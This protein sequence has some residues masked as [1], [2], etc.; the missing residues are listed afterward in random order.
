MIEYP[1]WTPF[2]TLIGFAFIFSTVQPN[3]FRS[4]MV[5]I[6][7]AFILLPTIVLVQRIA[8]RQIKDI[9]GT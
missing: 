2:V 7:L 8:E 1:I 6:G 9:K 4:A 5:I 3:D